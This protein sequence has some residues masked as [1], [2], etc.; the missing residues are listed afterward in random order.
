MKT[1]KC[2][3]T[4]PAHSDPV[5]AV[6]PPSV[7]SAGVT[8]DGGTWFAHMQYLNEQRP[9]PLSALCTVVAGWSTVRNTRGHFVGWGIEDQG[10]LSRVS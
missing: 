9:R 5:S 3:K 10:F 7:H 2:L 4:L 6:S 1:G 8:Q